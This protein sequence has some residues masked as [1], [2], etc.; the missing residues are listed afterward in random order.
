MAPSQTG[1]TTMLLRI[2]LIYATVLFAVSSLSA[3][4]NEKTHPAKPAELLAAIGQADKIVLYDGTAAVYVSGG[5]PAPRILYTSVNAKD[6]S[7]LKQSIVIEPPNG[8]FR[9]ACI[10]PIEIALS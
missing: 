8:W 5:D 7:E 3:D 6:I 10:P 2:G 4:D 1:A 9:C